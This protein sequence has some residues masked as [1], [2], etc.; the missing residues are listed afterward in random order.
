[1]K[2]SIIVQN[3]K[4]GG[5]AK[6]ITNAL[7]SLKGINDITVAVETAT[8]AFESV[9]MEDAITV[10]N[11]LKA[12]GYPSIDTNNSIKAKAKSF[13]SCASGKLNVS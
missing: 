9:T 1:M 12:L 11:T 3:L 4:C 2:T 5:C 6:T 8:V 7:S 13:V 10:K